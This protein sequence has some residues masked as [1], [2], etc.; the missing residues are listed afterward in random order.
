M[1]WIT[2]TEVN[3]AAYM[4]QDEIDAYRR[5]MGFDPTN[6]QSKDPVEIVLEDTAVM[7]R[8]YCHVQ[9]DEDNPF[10]IPRSLLSSAMAIARFR[11]LTR[12]QLDIQEDRRTDYEQAMHHLA[13]V[14]SGEVLVEPPSGEEQDGS[15]VVPLWGLSFRPNILR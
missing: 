13:L 12:M 5:L 8:G 15:R 1:A 14:A 7:V 9:L 2:P 6:G 3:L 11:L 10:S 4:A